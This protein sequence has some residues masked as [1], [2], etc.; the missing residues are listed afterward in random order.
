MNCVHSVWAV[1][2][3]LLL[4]LSPKPCLAQLHAEVY[5]SGLVEPVAM[6]QHP[7][8]ASIQFVAEQTGHI[9]VIKDGSLRDSDFLNVSAL[10]SL[11]FEQG[12]L[13]LAF[14]P[15]YDG[16]G[17]FYINYTDVL[18]N[19]EI[20]RF[21]RSIN[22]PFLAD[23]L[24]AYP[25]L[26]IFKPFYNHNG[27]TMNFGPDGY[28]YIGTGDGGGDPPN[29]PLNNAQTITDDLLGK[30]LRIDPSID[31]FLLDP[32]RNY[33]IPADNPFVAREGDDEIWSFGLRNPWKWSFDDP[34]KLGTGAMILGD[35]GWDSWEEIDYEPAGR[36]GRNYG[37]HEREGF[38][39][40]GLGGGRPPYQDP[41]WV[42]D[43]SHGQ[44][45][46]G[47]QVYRGLQLG[48]DFWGRY[49]FADYVANRVW[50]ASLTVDATS[51]E[52]ARVQ[53]GDVTEHSQ[54]LG[55][56]AFLGHISSVNCDADGELYLLSYNAG[57][58]LKVSRLN[59]VWPIDISTN[60]Q[61][62]LTGGLQALIAV[63]GKPV[64]LQ[65]N[66]EGPTLRALPL[67]LDVAWKTNAS[68]PNLLKLTVVARINQGTTGTL[69][70]LLLNQ[71]TGL[72][73][74]VG[75]DIVTTRIYETTTIQGVPAADYIDAEGR[76]TLRLL[77]S[78]D[79]PVSGQAFATDFDQLRIQ[80]Q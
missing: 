50:S 10:I 40:T 15:D 53:D 22:D 52:A 45:V 71:Q 35:V 25:I 8:D 39:E 80:V 44:A 64:E 13:G 51:G 34:A 46:T 58:I 14:P 66:L 19:L 69:R 60:E 29:D 6:V 77:S 23:P 11:S 16:S 17:Y 68:S 48:S 47:G 70:A 32:F 21:S 7:T 72:Y 56:F 75:D 76:I 20:V 28:L 49:F 4:L 9:R 33:G 38:E 61:G 54:E 2:A 42:Y 65:R 31:D 67:L 79:G 41:V 5:A 18:G 36:G 30:V 24:S 73:E 3:G 57:Q 62:L 37:W 63:D 27:G 12:L 1:L 74:Q 78:L 55:G 26:N 59:S 43:H